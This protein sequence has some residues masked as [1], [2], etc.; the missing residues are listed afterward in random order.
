MA[1]AKPGR[2]GRRLV[3]VGGVSVAVSELLVPISS[4]LVLR[5]SIDDVLQL[6]RAKFDQVRWMIRSRLRAQHLEFDD[7]STRGR[8]AEATCRRT[9]LAYVSC[10]TDCCPLCRRRSAECRRKSGDGR[11]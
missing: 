1:A 6:D 4:M 5:L 9:V 10:L 2:D 8:P 11:T 3:G 7:T